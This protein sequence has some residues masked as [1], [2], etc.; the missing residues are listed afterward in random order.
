MGFAAVARVTDQRWIAC[1]VRDEIAFGLQPGSELQVKTTICD[2]IRYSGRLVA[3][4]HVAADPVF[5]VHHTPAMYG[6]QSY[7]SVPLRR[8][9]GSFFGTLCAIDPMPARVNNVETIGMFTLFA[10]LIGYHL[11]AQDQLMAKEQALITSLVDFA[12]GKLGGVFSLDIELV[13]DLDKTIAHAIAELDAV[14]SG[15]PVIAEIAVTAPVRCDRIRL[16]QV[17]SNLVANALA[18]GDSSA[19]VVVR[20]HTNTDWFELTVENGGVIPNDR[21]ERLFEPFARAESKCTGLGLG[22]FISAEIARAHG[23]TLT[24]VCDATTTRFTLRLPH[25]HPTDTVTERNSP[26]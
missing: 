9:D 21:L 10:D 18:H 25:H 16:A 17:A 13:D 7:V 11:A 23:G 5:C 8:P 20:A 12:R 6:F 24:S 4:D 3:I 1:A 2:E 14:S 19:P 15:P 22:L 26:S